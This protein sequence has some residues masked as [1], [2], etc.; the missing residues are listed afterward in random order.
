M[1]NN[2]KIKKGI[3]S[4]EAIESLDKKKQR[5]YEAPLLSAIRSFLCSASVTYGLLIY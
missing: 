4:V 5:R 3:I 2:Q 1:F